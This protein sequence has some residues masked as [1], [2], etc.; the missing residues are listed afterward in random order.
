MT[1]QVFPIPSTL[2]QL[3]FVDSISPIT[4]FDLPA[5]RGKFGCKNTP[6]FIAPPDH[7]GTNAASKNFDTSGQIEFGI[8]HVFSLTKP[9]VLAVLASSDGLLANRSHSGPTLCSEK[10]C[11]CAPQKISD[12]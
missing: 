5:V 6:E 9:T 4:L 7:T 2:Q 12:Y 1:R 3:T 11:G 10:L 8:L